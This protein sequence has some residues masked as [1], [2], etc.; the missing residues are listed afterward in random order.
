MPSV[1]EI[2]LFR[3]KAGS[4][5]AAFLQAAQAT[6]ELLTSF[7]GYIDRELSASDDG[8][9]VDVV[10]W[11]TMTDAQQAAGHIMNHAAG[12]AFGQFIDPD[13]MAM[14]HVHPQLNG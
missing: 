10:H 9:W 3:L 4:D 1:V 2:V 7:K 14:Y 5:T 6:F 12:Q 11:A 13:T 8:Q